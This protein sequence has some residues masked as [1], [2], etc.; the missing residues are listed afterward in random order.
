LILQWKWRRSANDVKDNAYETPLLIYNR[1]MDQL[2][3]TINITISKVEKWQLPTMPR[4]RYDGFRNVDDEL[5]R[6]HANGYNTHQ[7]G[8][9]Q[10]ERPTNGIRFNSI[11]SKQNLYS[12]RLLSLHFILKLNICIWFHFHGFFSHGICY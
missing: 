1:D 3:L 8:F 9:Q 6:H 7:N 11:Y 4:R 5:G 12:L 2:M 10:S